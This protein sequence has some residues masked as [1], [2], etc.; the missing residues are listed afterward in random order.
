MRIGTHSAVVATHHV[1]EYLYTLGW[2]WALAVAVLWGLWLGGTPVR[3]LLGGWPSSAKSWL[4]D[5]GIA[6]AF[7]ASSALVLAMVSELLR[8]AHFKLPARTIS[9]LAPSS[10]AELMLFLVLSLSAGCC[11]ELLF[12]GYFQQQFSYLA[13]GRVWVGVA[14]SSLLFGCAHLYEGATGVVLITI[15]G[16]MFSLLAVKR[17]SLRPGIMAHAWH[18]GVSGLLLFLLQRSHIL[19]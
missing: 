19:S 14:A 5:A 18:D 12:R 17:Q 15:F 13:R 3:V 8:V 11:E 1:R 4:E 9:A 7:W 10:V 2:E 16:A 6:V